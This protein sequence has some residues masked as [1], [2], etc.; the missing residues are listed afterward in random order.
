[1]TIMKNIVIEIAMLLVVGLLFALQLNPQISRLILY[2]VNTLDISNRMCFKCVFTITREA[3]RA[4]VHF[5]TYGKYAI[6]EITK[7]IA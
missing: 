6:F 3:L 4:W 7:T 2:A 5:L 1:M